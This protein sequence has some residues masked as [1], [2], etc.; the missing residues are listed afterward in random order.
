MQVINGGTYENKNY[1]CMFDVN[2][3]H[4]Q[5][6]PN[7]LYYFQEGIQEADR[8]SCDKPAILIFDM[9]DKLVYAQTLASSSTYEQNV[10]WLLSTFYFLVAEAQIVSADEL[11]DLPFGTQIKIVWDNSTYHKK[12]LTLKG[13]IFGDKIGWEDGLVDEQGMIRES[14]YAGS[15]KVYLV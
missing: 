1:S 8:R 5:M 4:A 6:S 3:K 11:F 15:C 2:E 10:K 7:G 12:N 9:N 14:M 13:V